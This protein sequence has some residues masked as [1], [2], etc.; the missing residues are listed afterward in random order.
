MKN[1]RQIHFY[2][3]CLFAPLLIY[4][5]LSGAWQVFRLNNVPKEGPAPM[6]NSVLHELSNPH[7]HSTLPGANPKTDSSLMF[8]I[9]ALLM[10]IGLVVSALSGLVMAWQYS[11]SRRLV[12]FC[13][14]AGITIPMLLLF[15]K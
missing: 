7:T 8:K 2:L 1:L 15:L 12:L 14:G 3:G 13:A 10:A 6:L 9:V 11:R 5:S 4:F